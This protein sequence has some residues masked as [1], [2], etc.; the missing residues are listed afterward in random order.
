MWCWTYPELEVRDPRARDSI[1]A[2]LANLL[3]LSI[4]V[5]ASSTRSTS[6]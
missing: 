4:G 3:N 2:E 5:D 6:S 1:L